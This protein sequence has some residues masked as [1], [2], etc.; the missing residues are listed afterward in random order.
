[1]IDIPAARKAI[2]QTFVD[3]K[4]TTSYDQRGIAF[5]SAEALRLEGVIDM[6]LTQLEKEQAVS[7]E[8]RRELRERDRS[9]QAQLA[10]NL[11]EVFR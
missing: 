4:A 8:L 1:M 10:G 11:A 7:A 3:V 9:F 6:L 2:K 5:V